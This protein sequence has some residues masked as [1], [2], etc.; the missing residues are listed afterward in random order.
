MASAAGGYTRVTLA[1]SRRRVDIVVPS[2][3]PVGRLLPEA[4][5][6]TG[7]P[8]GQP[9]TL[10]HLVTADGTLLDADATLGEAGV[11][12]GAVLRVVGLAD[13]PPAAVIHDVTEEVADDL[14]RR[15]WRWG[16]VPRR[17]V[18]TVA[19]VAGTVLATD[20]TIGQFPAGGRLGADLVW[21]LAL[22][23]CGIVLATYATQPIGT[24]LILAGGATGV[25]A[26]WIGTGNLF[27]GGPVAAGVAAASLA[28]T[29]VALGL[30]TGI[31][32]GGVIGGLGGL[33]LIAAWWLPLAL[34]VPPLEVAAVLA[35]LSVVLLGV[36]PRLALGLSGMTGL[37]DRRSRNE[38]V[39][40]PA[41]ES[42]LRAAHRSLSLATLALAASAAV[43]GWLLTSTISPW[44]LPLTALMAA[45]LLSRARVFPLVPQVAGLIGAAWLAVLG[46]LLAWLR[47]DGTMR[48]AVIV[49]L[50][51]LVVIASAVLVVEP[52]D[53]VRARLRR[54]TDRLEAVTVI[55]MVPVALGVFGVYERLL[56]TF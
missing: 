52:P 25:L 15:A 14:D 3:E 33:V 30:S 38:Q 4:L 5:R 29:A 7:E 13:A 44:T 12:D 21:T 10:R 8:P 22:L 45:S 50:V 47:A 54:L 34:G 46:L 24:A 37:D 41:V 23:L 32:S 9:P 6:L 2:D 26:G 42:A 55:A 36:L 39:T 35:V 31:G 51:L 16:P 43:A 19:I 27:G 56:H 28:A 53:H 48:W 1:G 18:G 40:R 49:G 20:L 17:W 11:P